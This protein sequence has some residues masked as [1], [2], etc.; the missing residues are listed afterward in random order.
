MTL[1]LKGTNSVVIQS[2]SACAIPC[3]TVLLS[4]SLTCTGN[5]ASKYHVPRASPFTVNVFGTDAPERGDVIF[6]ISDTSG[7]T[8][9]VAG[10][11]GSAGAGVTTTT[12][13]KATRTKK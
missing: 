12:Q 11:G 8:T 2:S 4:L 3:P 10:G 7:S 6:T 1:A 13:P 5:D 9:G